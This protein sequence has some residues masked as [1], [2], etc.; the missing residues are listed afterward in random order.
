MPIELAELQGADIDWSLLG[1]DQDELAM[2]LD[3]GVKQGLS[4]PDDVP[5]PPDEAVTQSGDLWALGSH[6]L[7]CGDSANADD[8][9]RL[10]DGQP[11]HL[12]NTDPPYN[13]K[14]EPR[15]NN[16][17]AA[18]NSSFSLMKHQQLTQAVDATRG[19]KGLHHHQAFD[20]A[21][22]GVSERPAEPLLTRALSWRAC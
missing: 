5:E 21:R 7:L 4:D 1:F 11:I 14:V 13:V 2:L 17:I 6:R 10:L 19:G 8:V 22:Q 16:A 9:D 3:P 15:S 12:V 20:V 18:G